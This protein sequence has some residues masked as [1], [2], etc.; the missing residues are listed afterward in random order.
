VKIFMKLFNRQ[1]IS[2][3]VP[4]R[5]VPGVAL[6]GFLLVIPPAVFAQG[7][8]T[9]GHW[10]GT[11]TSA[12]V[13]RQPTGS[14]ASQRRA[15]QQYSELNF[16]N[17]TLRQIVHV[18]L[19]GERIRVV[20]TNVFGTA[21]LAIG[22][23]H[24]ALRDKGAAIVPASGRVLTFGG[25]PTTTMAAGAVAVSDPVN[26]NVSPLAD[27]AIDVYLPG[28]TSATMSPLTVHAAAWQTNYVS[29]PGNHAGTAD[30]PVQTTTSYVRADGLQSSSWFFLS[31]VE[32]MAPE[33]VGALVTFGDSISDG[34]H[35]TQDTNNR[36]PDHL[37]RR[38]VSQNV[39][40]AVLN[41]G[42]GGNRLLDDGPSVS[43]LA[44]FDRDVLVQTG[45]TRVVVLLGINDI[46]NA[47]QSPSPSAADL[48]AGH[49]QLIERAHALGLKIYGATLTPFE[50]AN[51]WTPEGEAKRKAL[52]EWIRTSKAYDGMIDFDAVARDPSHPARCLPRYD[53]GDHLHLN[54]AGY[55]AMANAIDLELLKTKTGLVSSAAR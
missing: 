34:T 4:S 7:G 33:R 3:R 27:L 24:I 29:P 17:Q 36:W 46:G 10:I 16:N 55:Q 38:L 28:D 5:I 18:S 9:G 53:P 45:A 43:G 19:G 14:Q 11:W 42:I 41:A 1:A 22:A 40:M 30:M 12:P 2:G 50:G 23:A 15:A 6:A 49:K 35:S 20:F 52:N 8:K 44:R 47:R 48:I 32:V 37:A 13:A 51:Y 26:L 54:A 25:N 21:P 31:R 39:K